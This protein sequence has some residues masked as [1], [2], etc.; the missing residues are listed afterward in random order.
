MYLYCHTTYFY[1]ESNIT[2]FIKG[3]YYRHLGNQYMTDDKLIMG[4]GKLL[5]L[6]RYFLLP[7]EDRERKINDILC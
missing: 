4:F 2:L 6:R 1:R 3:N 5:N 7:E